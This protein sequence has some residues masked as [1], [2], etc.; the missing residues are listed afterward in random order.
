MRILAVRVEPVARV[1]CIIYAFLG[2][3]A[4]LVFWFADAQFLTLPFGIVAPLV[5]LNININLPRSTNLFYNLFCCI[6][7][8]VA[9]AVTGWITGAAAALCFNLVAKQRGGID[10][11]YVSTIDG[12]SLPELDH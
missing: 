4:F 10:T 12:E 3:P 8:I 9:Y 6:A 5:H 11:K 1:L 7:E 2:L